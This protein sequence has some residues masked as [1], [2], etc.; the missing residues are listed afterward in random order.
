[1]ILLNNSGLSK[2][3]LVD[4]NTYFNTHTFET[5]FGKVR[6]EKYRLGYCIDFGINKFVKDKKGNTKYF[7]CVDEALKELIKLCDGEAERVSKFI[8]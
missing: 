6:I 4:K 5:I 8:Y 1:M 3:Y 2:I 7:W